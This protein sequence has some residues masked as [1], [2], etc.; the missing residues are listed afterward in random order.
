MSTNNDDGVDW[1]IVADYIGH[2]RQ[3]LRLTRKAAADKARVSQNTW[4]GLEEGRGPVP[5]EVTLMRIADALERPPGELFK[6]FGIPAPRSPVRVKRSRP[7]AEA[8]STDPALEPD[9]RRLL[10]QLYERLTRPDT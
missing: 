4:R 7:M 8:I 1:G 10:G 3:G 9:D 6:I 2:H 5:K